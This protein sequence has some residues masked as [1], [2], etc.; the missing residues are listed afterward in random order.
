MESVR[1]S[2]MDE[3]ENTLMEDVKEN[4]LMEDVKENTLMENVKVKDIMFSLYFVLAMV[5]SLL[6]IYTTSTLPLH[7]QWSMYN[8]T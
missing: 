2:S 1:V 5:V 6:G 7:S 8:I 3:E 4:T